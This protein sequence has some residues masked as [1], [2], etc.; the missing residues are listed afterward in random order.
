MLSLEGKQLG[1]YDVIRRIRS[2]GMGA[3]YEGRQRTAFDRRVAIKVILGDYAADRDMRRR[4]A[5][6]AKTIAR[7]HHPHILQLIEFGDAQGILYLVMPFI[8]GGTLTS[9][10]RRNL[11]EL[12]EVSAIYQQLLDAVEYAHEAGLIHRD[13]KSSNVLLE[14]RRNAPPYVYLADFGLVRTMRHDESSQPGKPIPLEQVPGTPHYMA[15]EQTLGI[16][17]SLTDIYALGVLLYQMLTGNLPYNDPNEVRVIEM[18]LHDPI[19]APSD[20]DA[21]IPRELDAVVRKAMAKRPEERYS[22]VGEL[23]AAFLAAVSG[24]T[25]TPIH[26]EN[27]LPDPPLP[28]GPMETLQQRTTKILNKRP[29]EPPEPIIM[30]RRAPRTDSRP[31]IVA[32]REVRERVEKAEKAERVYTTDTVRPRL[33]ITEEPQQRRRHSLFPLL[34]A[35]V[36]L[37]LIALLVL[38]RLLGIS[39]IPANV[40]LVGSPTV[41]TISITAQTAPL[42]NTF[43]LTASPLAKAP[44]LDAHTIPDRVIRNAASDR[45]TIPTTGI[46]TTPGARASGVLELSNDTDNAV[47]VQRGQ[48]FSTGAG[49]NVQLQQ[50]VNVPAHD[51]GHPGKATA[52]ASVVQP[53]SA[54]NIPANVL[55]TTCCNDA[56]TIKNPAAFMGGTDSKTTHYVTQADLDG[57]QTTISPRL[58]RQLSM[59]TQKQI[60]PDEVIVGQTNFKIT[61]VS[62]DRAVNDTVDTVTVSVN[63]EAST[64]VY[65]HSV[66]EQAAV[67]LLNRQAA[68]TLSSAYQL[69]DKP[70][71]VG[72]PSVQS[73]KDGIVH[74]NV[75]VRGTW[76]YAF[77][78]QQLKQFRTPIKGATADLAKTYLKTQSGIAN[79]DVRL[80]FG[81]DHLPNSVDDIT[82][83]VTPLAH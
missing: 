74:L 61:K 8:D 63:A 79:V 19:P 29:V 24:P 73:S 14:L 58:Q 45:A 21:S 31:P 41:A 36:S 11:P 15:P 9:Y 53:G 34:A 80:P 3:V 66:V 46:Q 57:V 51:N 70:T 1:N 62:S 10:L 81:M 25:P 26:N 71:L 27:I 40:P 13:I 83:N 47:T 44:D 68:R 28:V 49:I 69:Q 82:I 54:G 75:S 32:V 60:V 22:S 5:R 77:T 33:R 64:T 4:F 43:L 35:I 2:G 42:Q 65:R 39:I 7:L 50:S 30:P 67:V 78:D 37:V 12:G 48:E 76:V 20:Q 16:V 52:P 38:P 56:V 59:Q 23:R 17:T 6:E 72:I 18:H 55:K